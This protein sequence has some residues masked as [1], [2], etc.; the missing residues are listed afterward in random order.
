MSGHSHWAGIKQKKGAADARRSKVF[1]KLAQELTLAAKEG[2]DP[3]ANPRLRSVVEK[4][5]AE[6]MPSDNIDR[7]IKRGAGGEGNALEE[8][9]FEAYGPGGI[10]VLLAGITDNKNRALGEIKQALSKHQGKL[11]EGGAVQWM[12]ERKGC[13]TIPTQ[14]TIKMKSKEEIELAAIEAGAQ[15]IYWNESDSTLDIYTTPTELKETQ[16]HLEAQGLSANKT[17]L[18][19]VPKERISVSQ[20]TKEATERLFEALDELDSIHDIYSNL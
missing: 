4:A 14:E 12:F 3:A 2:G 11:V 9:L 13:I 10:A 17:S 8:V 18:E 5:H 19:W 16:E 7:A 1:S 20:E 6:N 15:D